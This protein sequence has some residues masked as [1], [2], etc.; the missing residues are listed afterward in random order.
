MTLIFNPHKTSASNALLSWNTQTKN[1][2]AYN[3][4]IKL[5]STNRILYFVHFGAVCRS[6]RRR[7]VA[8]CLTSPRTPPSYN[9]NAIQSFCSR[10][11]R[12]SIVADGRRDNALLWHIILPFT[13]NP[14]LMLPSPDGWSA[15]RF[16]C[17]TFPFAIVYLTRIQFFFS[18]PLTVGVW[19]T[20]LSNSYTNIHTD[21]CPT[22]KLLSHRIIGFTNSRVFCA[23]NAFVQIG[24]HRPH[25][26]HLTIG[27]RTPIRTN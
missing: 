10:F 15:I 14:A 4:H 23:H 26:D 16:R 5:N 27:T 24:S 25:L 13:C 11:A 8:A 1:S 9:T 7:N 3:S 12:L 21:G 6:A 17:I 20:G 2:S 22:N 18:T 19:T